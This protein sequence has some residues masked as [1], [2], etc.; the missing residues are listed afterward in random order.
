M[1]KEVCTFGRQP[2]EF[3]KIKRSKDV[4]R[5]PRPKG[6]GHQGGKPVRND[7]TPPGISSINASLVTDASASISWT[8]SEEA[9]CVLHYGLT[10]SYGST[11]TSTAKT[12][13]SVGL[14]GLTPDSIYHFKIVATD[15]AG[16]IT[17]S[18]D[19][20]FSTIIVPNKVIY[21]ELYGTTISG[22]MWNTSGAIIAGHSGFTESEIDELMIKIQAHFSPYNVLVTND[23][24]IYNATSYA[25][26][27]RVVITESNEWYG[28]NA[29]G[30][31]Y[32]NSW[33]WSDQAP[34]FVFSKLLG[35]NIHY[36]AEAAAHEIGHILGCYHQVA[37]NNGVITSEYNPGDG[38]HAPTMGVSYYVAAGEWWVGPMSYG[39]TYMQDDNAIIVA[40]LGL[41]P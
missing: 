11:K 20:T 30:V 12:G 25:V 18:T 37:C 39:C 21:V 34:G 15:L 33:G 7:T 10:T 24:D 4:E 22:T 41:K 38:V 31:A 32:I 29:G 40:K 2:H 3:N 13:H 9:S 19:N 17:T 26:K 35:Y 14:S 27:Q 5:A 23:I 28:N 36:C 6:G 16:N 1:K 8:T